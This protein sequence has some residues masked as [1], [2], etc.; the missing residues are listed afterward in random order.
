MFSS[1]LTVHE[2]W[3]KDRR[4]K[5]VDEMREWEGKKLQKK[6]MRDVFEKCL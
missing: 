2:S 6:A 4:R 1:A 3:V 5:K